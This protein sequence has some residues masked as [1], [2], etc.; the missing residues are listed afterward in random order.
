M[1]YHNSSVRGNESVPS[2][3]LFDKDA[4]VQQAGTTTARVVHLKNGMNPYLI[5]A[6]RCKVHF[7][8]IV[9]IVYIS[10]ENWCVCIV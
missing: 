3:F 8:S 1:V 10:M 6:G 2:C 9:W 5:T 4:H 7:I